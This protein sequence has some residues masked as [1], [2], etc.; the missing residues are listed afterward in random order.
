M[1][2]ID[3]ALLT[4]YLVLWCCDSVWMA[5]SLIQLFSCNLWMSKLHPPII[6]KQG[7][8]MWCWSPSMEK[9]Y[10]WFHQ[11]RMK[12]AEKEVC[13][14]CRGGPWGREGINLGRSNL[15]WSM[16]KGVYKWERDPSWALTLSS[17]GWWYAVP[18]KE[19]RMGCNICTFSDDLS[20]SVSETF[21]PIVSRIAWIFY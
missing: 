14:H 20:K 7:A 8:I 17:S 9:K 12:T 5:P 21:K 2:R 16:G 11:T 3:S 18:L 6:D 4:R 19:V 13:I 10:M 1:E 15:E